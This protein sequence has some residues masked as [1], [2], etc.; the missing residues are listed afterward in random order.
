MTAVE[1]AALWK[2]IEPR[3]RRL[4]RHAKWRVTINKL[5]ALQRP[6]TIALRKSCRSPLHV[7]SASPEPT[8]AARLR[9][10]SMA[11]ESELEAGVQSKSAREGRPTQGP[12]HGCLEERGEVQGWAESKFDLPDRQ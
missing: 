12:S 1:S 4:C 2:L 6:C 3:R 9:E 5:S 10:A 8:S 11:R 7:A